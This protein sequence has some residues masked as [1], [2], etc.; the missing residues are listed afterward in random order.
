MMPKRRVWCKISNACTKCPFSDRSH[1][2]LAMMQAASPVTYDINLETLFKVFKLYKSQSFSSP[3]LSTRKWDFDKVKKAADYAYL[4]GDSKTKDKG[5]RNG[6][7]LS[8]IANQVLHVAILGW[9]C[10]DN[11]REYRAEH[12][13]FCI[14]RFEGINSAPDTWDN[15]S[16][17]PHF[18]THSQS[19]VVELRFW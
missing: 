16:C 19:E 8:E 14:Y 10:V 18:Y 13:N 6:V 3:V 12:T 9:K 4:L 15:R 17:S 5:N 11:V 7:H 1:M 2:S